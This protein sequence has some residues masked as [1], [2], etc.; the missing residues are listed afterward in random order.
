VSLFSARP[1]RRDRKGRFV[2]SMSEPERDL[3]A[4]LPGQLVELLA[5][6]DEPSLQRL[7]PPAYAQPEDAE[8]QADYARLMRE[9]LLHRHEEALATM[10]ATAH[11]TELTEEEMLG[12]LHSLNSLRLVLGTRLDVSEDDDPMADMTP[13]RQL[14]YLLGYWQESVIAALAGD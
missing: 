4:A 3:I 6:P 5:D 2:V 9:D 1:V 13:E 12:W 7:F 8:R 14:Y 10:A 11:A